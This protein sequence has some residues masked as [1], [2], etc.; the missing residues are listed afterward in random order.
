MVSK[1]TEGSDC[2]HEI[3]THLL[4]GRKAMENLD[5]VKKRRRHLANKVHLVKPVIYPVVISGH[6]SWIIKKV[7]H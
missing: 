3:K 4:F 2:N 5:G 7:E 6:E 1:I